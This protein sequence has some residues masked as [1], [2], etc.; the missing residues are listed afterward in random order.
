MTRTTR[1]YSLANPTATA[2]FPHAPASEAAIIDMA[3]ARTV[4]LR[5]RLRNHYWLRGCVPLTT[6]EIDLQRR[7]MLMIREADGVDEDT[8]K[9]LLT[10]LYGFEFGGEGWVI[11]DLDYHRT[12]VLAAK[13][14]AAA[15][16]AAGGRASA[17]KRTPPAPAAQ[18]T[19]SFTG[20]TTVQSSPTDA[21]DF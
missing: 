3:D 4:A 8:I 21:E 5:E 2:W 13:A 9:A 14:K 12:E 10:P 20:P 17:G 19:T 7:K 15:L 16:G 11:P 6:A 1:S 18:P